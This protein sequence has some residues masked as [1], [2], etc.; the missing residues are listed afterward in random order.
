VCHTLRRFGF[1]VD[2]VFP[3][4]TRWANVCR[5]AGARDGEVNSPLQT[6]RPTLAQFAR[7]GAPGAI[8]T[9]GFMLELTLDR[10]RWSPTETRSGGTVCWG[11]GNVK[12]IVAMARIRPNAKKPGEARCGHG[13]PVPLRG[14]PVLR[15]ATTLPSDG[16]C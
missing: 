7:I 6:A 14:A 9:A 5:A 16:G 13:C 3:A 2:A 12:G 11:E 15:P 10:F 4:L 8:L 1:S